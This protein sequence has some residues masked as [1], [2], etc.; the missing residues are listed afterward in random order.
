MIDTI[1]MRRNLAQIP[2]R[3][4]KAL[5]AY[6][7]TA[8]ALLQG[9]AQKNRPWMDRTAQAR[10]RIKGYCVKT[11]TGVRIYLAHGVNYG[12]FLEFANE[13]KYAIIYPTLRRKGPEIISAA[14][15]VVSRK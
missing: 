9:E 14:V 12:V 4:E 2:E 15:K 11:D 10:Q 13:K 6:G 8:A 5:M 3:T 1:Q 7:K